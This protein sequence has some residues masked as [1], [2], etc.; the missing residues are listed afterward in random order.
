[1]SNPTANK[2]DG[3]AREQAVLILGPHRSGTSAVTG[4]LNLL[5]VELGRNLMPS[6]SDNRLGFW[7]H[8]EIFEFHE[9]LLSNLGSAWHDYRPLEPGWS[10]GEA[11]DRARAGLR[12]LVEEEL[13]GAPLW[14][15]K[16]PRLSRLLP[17][18]SDLLHELGT[19]ARFVI[20]VRNPMEVVRSL[21][22]RNGFTATKSLLLWISDTLAALENTADRR[23]TFVSF[24]QLLH[25]PGEAI[26]S[27]TRDLELDWPR[28]P[29]EVAAEID[30]FLRPGERHHRVG[31]EALPGCSYL[32]AWCQRL[33]EALDRACRGEE[34]DLAAAFAAARKS[35]TA[36]LALFQDDLRREAADAAER[37]ASL[38]L[39]LALL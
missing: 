21:I 7:E 27:M 37:I 14:G 15:V 38:E 18:W 24:E 17:L 39:Q 4:V 19:D 1:M 33:Y 23:R 34:D 11:A 31:A 22:R 6:K 20:V 29:G 8:D 36:S 12:S 3:S 35:F 28:C 26:R 9:E 13:A 5:G 32:P 16:D 30:A 10:A 25:D 2:P